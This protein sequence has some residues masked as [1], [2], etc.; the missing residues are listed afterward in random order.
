[1][2]YFKA[3]EGM[4]DILPASIDMAFLETFLPDGTYQI[5]LRCPDGK[6][7]GRQI[8]QISKTKIN[9][10]AKQTSTGGLEELLKTMLI[11]MEQRENLLLNLFKQRTEPQT[12]SIKEI[13]SLIKETQP[14][15]DLTTIYSEILRTIKELEKGE[16]ELKMMS[17]QREEVKMYP[18]IEP[19]QPPPME[20]N[21]YEILKNLIE[22]E[23]ISKIVPEQYK[24]LV[25][26]FINKDQI[27]AILKNTFED[28]AL[29]L[30][31]QEELSFEIDKAYY[32]G[33]IQGFRDGQLGKVSL[34]QQQEQK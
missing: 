34:K 25:S 24:D 10:E 7:L 33:Y 5:L 32:N 9:T 22:T 18:N 4:Q 14:K 12:L 11:K 2:K 21:A 28:N 6:L 31:S 30:L 19:P 17:M 20:M 27:I 26:K 1:K 15:V 13:L 3:I 23:L 8:I 29:F 16:K